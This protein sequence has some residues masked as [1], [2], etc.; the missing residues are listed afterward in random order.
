MPELDRPPLPAGALRR[1]L[2][3]PGGLWRRIDV[4]PETGSTNADVAEAARRG[5]PE[6]LVVVA[7]R[8]VAGRGRRDRLWLSPPRAGLTFSVLLR[9]AVAQSTWSWLPLLAGV[10]LCEA[11]DSGAALKWP[12]DLLIGDAKCAGVL[13]EVV[14]DA[15]VL[16]IGL[17]VTTRPDELPP[18]TSGPPPTSL[19]LAGATNTDRGALLRSLLGGLARWYAGWRAAGGAAEPSGLG[20]AYRKMCAT[21]GRRVT[22]HLPTGDSLTGDAVTVD[23]DGQLVVHTG[24]GDRRVSAGDVLHIR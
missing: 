15:V 18:A 13:A 8:Q 14:G 17:N 23:G 21:I 5:E 7:E 11:V 10:A 20:D 1:A 2:I 12:N 3:R 6:G 22:I 24:G 16:G 9:P 4:L 19:L